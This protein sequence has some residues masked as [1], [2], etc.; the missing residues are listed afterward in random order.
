MGFFW[1]GGGAAVWCIISRAANFLAH[2]SHTKCRLQSHEL[3]TICCP[4]LSVDC[5]AH[6]SFVVEILWESLV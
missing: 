5:V 2:L 4:N 3:S 6:Y 1:G